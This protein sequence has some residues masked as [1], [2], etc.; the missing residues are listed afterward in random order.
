[1]VTHKQVVDCVLNY[2]DLSYKVDLIRTYCLENNKDEMQ[3]EILLTA[4]RTMPLLFNQL[5][6]YIIE[7]KSKEFNIVTIYNKNQQ[8]IHIY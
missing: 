6:N 3:I 2:M 8:L 5:A 1:M 7:E 4:C